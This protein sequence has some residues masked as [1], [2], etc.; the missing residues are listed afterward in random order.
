[1]RVEKGRG[2]LRP[3]NIVKEGPTIRRGTE[4]CLQRLVAL[5]SVSKKCKQ[6]RRHI[7][8][9]FLNASSD[10]PA[11]NIISRVMGIVSSNDFISLFTDVV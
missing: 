8:D 2:H 9:C 7:H 11:G 6:G 3:A 4:P 1:M 10:Y 5:H